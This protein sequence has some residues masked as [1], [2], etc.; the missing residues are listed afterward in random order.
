MHEMKA[1]ALYLPNN[2]HASMRVTDPEAFIFHN[3]N[4]AIVSELSLM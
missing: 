4:R 3:L 1:T 2:E